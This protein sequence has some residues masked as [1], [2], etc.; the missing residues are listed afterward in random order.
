MEQLAEMMDEDAKARH[1]AH[2]LK[3][4]L[5][6]RM[7]GNVAKAGGSK[8]KKGQVAIKSEDARD[9]GICGSPSVP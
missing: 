9:F 4:L 7:G 6:A 2:R 8:S 3:R 1:W 5:P